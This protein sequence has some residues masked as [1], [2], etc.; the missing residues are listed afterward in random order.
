MAVHR[1]MAMAL[2]PCMLPQ[3]QQ[4]LRVLIALGPEAPPLAAYIAVNISLGKGDPPLSTP[5]TLSPNP[6]IITAPSTLS[7]VTNLAV[8]QHMEISPIYLDSNSV[9]PV[10]SPSNFHIPQAAVLIDPSTQVISFEGS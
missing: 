2:V 4:P 6:N 10:K 8:D 1:V 9:D 3:E 7:F 5:F